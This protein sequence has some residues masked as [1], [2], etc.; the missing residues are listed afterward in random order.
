MELNSARL[1]WTLLSGNLDDEGERFVAPI[2][3]G[4]NG[5]TI[6]KS[7]GQLCLWGLALTWPILLI[8]SVIV[9]VL[10]LNL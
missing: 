5:I 1:K 2:Q 10:L 6:P 4:T 8:G 3:G 9:A 7:F